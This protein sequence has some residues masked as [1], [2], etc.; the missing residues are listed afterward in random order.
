MLPGRSIVGLAASL[1]ALAAAGC[2]DAGSDSGAT[3]PGGAK[4][5]GGAEGGGAGAPGGSGG[6]GGSSSPSRQRKAAPATTRV[7]RAWADA[8]RRGDVR[9]AASYFA[10]PSVVQNGTP[11]VRLGEPGEALAFNLSL[12]CGARLKGTRRTGR[13]TVATFALTERPGGDCGKG[14]GG[15]AVTAFVVTG[16]KI[17]EWRR[18]P[19]PGEPPPGGGTPPPPQEPIPGGPIV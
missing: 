18:V 19:A 4:G 3:R 10:I 13:Y 8:L 2:G 14:T 5:G 9:R 16:G 17:R 7:I 11:P 12:P 6:S 15:E 1:L